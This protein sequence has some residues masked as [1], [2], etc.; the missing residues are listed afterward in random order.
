MKRA[1]E[2][3]KQIVEEDADFFNDIFVYIC[4]SRNALDSKEI[5]VKFFD[6][7]DGDKKIDFEHVGKG[8]NK[9]TT[10]WFLARERGSPDLVAWLREKGGEQS[11]KLRKPTA[12][13]WVPLRISS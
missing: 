13:G 10:A 2:K 5:A 8:L 11:E 3:L 9:P 1:G 7:F 12:K 4:G 6:F